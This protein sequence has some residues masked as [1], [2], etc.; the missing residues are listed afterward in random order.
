MW[1]N[2]KTYLITNFRANFKFLKKE[3]FMQKASVTNSRSHATKW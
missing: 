3:N 1:L 2:L